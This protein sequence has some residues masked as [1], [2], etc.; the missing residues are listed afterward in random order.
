MPILTRPASYRLLLLRLLHLNVGLMAFGLGIACVLT[1]GIGVGPW[2]AFHQGL[3]L[4]LPFT[5]G[6]VMVGVGLAVLLISMVVAKVR[7]G[8][9][10]VFNMALVGP[11]VD[12]W[13][14]QSYMQTPDALWQKLAIFAVGLAINGLATGLYITAGLG[15]GPRDGFYIGLAKLTKAPVARVRMATEVLVLAIGWLLGGTIGWGTVVFSL[16]MGPLMQA[17]LRLCRGLDLRYARARDAALA[18]RPRAA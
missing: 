8:I 12:L 17:S 6:Q 13:L 2:D 10:T 5:I 11:W 14:A 18:R 16:T 15:A 4:H 1:A 7:P 3:A 9:A